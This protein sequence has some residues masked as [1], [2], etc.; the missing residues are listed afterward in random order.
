MALQIFEYK[1]DIWLYEDSGTP[2]VPVTMPGEAG[3]I[4]H[5]GIKTL[6][7]V[8]APDYVAPIV[9]K[10]T[11]GIASQ[12]LAEL[13]GGALLAATTK[14]IILRPSATGIFVN[15]SDP[16]AV[17]DCPLGEDDWEED[18]DATSLANL[19]FVAAAPITAWLIENGW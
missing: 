5:Q 4:L 13:K 16:A 8:I 14:R 9:T 17:T 15:D 3:E 1:P 18:G 7:D 2:G 6:A 11:V 10:V 19:E 12:T